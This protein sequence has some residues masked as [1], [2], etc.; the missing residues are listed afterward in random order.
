MF[1][2]I[3]NDLHHTV[4]Q[5]KRFEKGLNKVS[6]FSLDL[7]NQTAKFLGSNE[8]TYNTT[9]SN[10]T[11]MDYNVRLLPCKHMYRLAVECGIINPNESP[12]NEYKNYSKI[13]SKV[14]KKIDTLNVAE[15][16]NLDKY[17]DEI[18]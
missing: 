7:E 5:I 15:L 13:Y 4:D 11:C 6:P 18:L 14:K 1:E 8:N 16:K 12:W 10:C 3:N 2:D 9:L 17:L